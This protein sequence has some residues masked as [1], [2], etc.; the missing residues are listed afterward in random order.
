[1]SS[2][3]ILNEK[4]YRNQ[5]SEPKSE[6]EKGA[7]DNPVEN[8][9]GVEVFVRLSAFEEDKR[10]DKVKRCLRSGALQLHN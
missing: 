2:I 1:L 10:I 3:T 5:A 9:S 4:Q 6:N 7:L 8:A